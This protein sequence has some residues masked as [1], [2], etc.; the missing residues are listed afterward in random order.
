MNACGK[1]ARCYMPNRQCGF[2]LV[3]AVFMI[4]TVALL[5]TVIT[6]M[7]AG[8]VLSG[9]QH[10]SSAKAFFIAESGREKGVREW[11]LNNG[12]TGETNTAFADGG[13]TI[14][15]SSTDFSGN[16]LPSGNIRIISAGRVTGGNTA[17]TTE[18]IVGPEN[19]LPF[20]ANADFNQAPSNPCVQALGCQ[21]TNWFLQTQLPAG[22]DIPI[23]RYTPWDDINP[24]P[25]T[26]TDRAAYAKK[27]W[28]GPDSATSAG[29]F[30]FIPAISVTAPTTVT[31]RF[32]YWIQAGNAS[33]EAYFTFT[34]SDGTT[35]WTSPVT[36][37]PHTGQ[38]QTMSTT[39]S[40]TGTGTKTI[41][42]LGF[43]LELRAG[44]PKEGWLDNIRISSGANPGLVQ[45]FWRERFG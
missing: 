39:I 36:D 25:G 1:M 40:I 15:T 35:T 6:F 24:A 10:A 27:N 20:T 30:T 19:L 44:Q 31:L 18:S 26:S 16:P 38:W 42:N 2:L 11:S 4:V 14:S 45:K 21:P 5:A 43:T 17:R 22:R 13:F 12:Y 8:N 34:L 37:S 9:A 29:N 7:T 32:D 28:N 23:N 33:K 41:T 3:A